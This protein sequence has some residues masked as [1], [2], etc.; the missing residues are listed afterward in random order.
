MQNHHLLNKLETYYPNRGPLRRELYVKHMAFFGAGAT[1][2]ERLAI[3]GNRVGKTEGLLCYEVACHLTGIYPDWWPGRRF[4]KPP[5]GW[6]AGK[7]SETTR[8]IL[9]AKLLGKTHRDRESGAAGEVLGLGTGMIPRQYIA[10]TSPKSGVPDGVDTAWIRHVSG[11][12]SK[13]GFKSY[14]KDRDSFEGTEKDFIGLDEEPPSSVDD[15]CTARLMATRPGERGGI[16]IITFTPL[17]GYTEVVKKFFE[18]DD[19][20]RWYIQIGWRD[21]PHLSE[22]EIKRMSSKYLPSQLKARSEGEPALGEGAIYPKD[23]EE[24]LVDDF[25]I[26]DAWPRGFGMDVGKTAVIWGALNRD[27]DV[28]YLYREYYSEV[29]NTILHAATI[30]GIGDRDKWIPGVVDPAANGSSQVDGRK[31]YEIYKGLGVNV[32]LAEAGLV[33]SGIEAVWNRMVT[34]RLKVFK[35]LSRWRSEYN[36]YHR[37]T[38][39]T[40]IGLQSVI[41]K[42][43]DHCLDATRYMCVSGIDR[44]KTKPAPQTHQAPTYY[45][46]GQG[47]MA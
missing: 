43:D 13:V 27:T 11:G 18:G 30:K 24:L 37:I 9:Q 46:G 31:L 36:R 23:I 19:P 33:N 7:T 16:K 15:E 6:L 29:Y 40:E 25:V 21:A 8:D 38:K 41:V 34:G 1:Y 3:C 47:W 44:F 2:D 35:S 20:G 32:H 45:P 4:D 42:R 28:L 39:E 5:D 10:S 17:A 12:Y 14:G 26:P 22:S